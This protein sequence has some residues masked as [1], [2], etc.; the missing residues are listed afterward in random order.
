MADEEIKPG[1]IV[2][3]KCGGSKMMAVKDSNDTA[4]IWCEWTEDGKH[5]FEEFYKVGLEVV[6]PADSG[7]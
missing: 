2:Q 5:R 6:D 3:Q 7:L 1:L 4:K